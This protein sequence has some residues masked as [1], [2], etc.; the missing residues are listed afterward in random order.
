MTTMKSS[1]SRESRARAF[2]TGCDQNTEWMLEWFVKHYR[3][4]N[5]TDLVFANFGVSAEMKEKLGFLGFDDIIEMPIQ[6][7]QG[8]FYKPKAMYQTCLMYDEVCWLDTDIHITGDMSTLFKYVEDGKLAMCED[9]GWTKRRG[10]KW[11]NSGVVAMRGV[12]RILPAWE[13]ECSNNPKVGDQ[14]VLHEMVRVTPLE[15]EINITTLPPR[16]NWLRLDILD[17]LDS[18]DKV[19]M[20]WTGHKGKLQIQKMMYNEQ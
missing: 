10:E 2:L 18:N 9:R 14:E 3:K 20:H 5:K 12:P 6:R 15:R 11:H 13:K 16:Y 8:W 17:G 19:A 1:K 4:H 7:G